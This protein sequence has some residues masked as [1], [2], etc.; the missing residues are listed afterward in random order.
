MSNTPTRGSVSGANLS[1]AQQKAFNVGLIDAM[2]T[3]GMQEGDRS[4]LTADTTLDVTQCGLVPVD[5]TGG[6]VAL[7]LPA[8]GTTTKDA[9]YLICR[10]DATANTLS[11]N[12]GGSDA[13][14][15]SASA[16][17]IAGRGI[18]GLQLP[19]GGTDWKVIGRSGGTQGGARTAIGLGVGSDIASAS[20]VDLTARTGK[21][22]RIT[23]TTTTTVVTMANG[24]E[25]LCTAAG[26]WPINISGVLTHTC[27]AGDQIL[28]SQ[29]NSGAQ[30][31]IVLNRKNPG[32]VQGSFKN[33]VVSTTGTNATVTASADE[34]SV[35]DGSGNYYTLRNVS[36][37]INSAASGAN[38]L[39]TGSIA[40]STWYSVWVGYNP[41]TNTAIGLLS[42][43]N[44]APTM[45]SGY[46]F[47]ARISR[48]RTDGTANK[49]PLG[50]KQ[51]NRKAQYLVAS[52]GNLTALPQMVTG[53][54]GNLGTPTWVSVAVDNFV[55]DTA[56]AID[57]VSHIPNAGG[58]AAGNMAAPN[59]SYGAYNSG[60][61]PPPLVNF[62]FVNSGAMA[63]RQTMTLESANIYF[64]GQGTQSLYCAGWEDNL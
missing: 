14:E 9:V 61:N 57:V 28:F 33:L 15:G 17:G 21:I 13:I 2:R 36:L 62:P 5:C 16:V 40:G 1:G 4:T 51:A 41:A 53:A 20:T 26:A 11:V 49:Y 52:G 30:K 42:L 43:S 35:G 47:K 8:S 25:V 24:D 54:Q 29:D 63:V 6:N 58:G 48:V 18:L 3:A 7:T 44:S 23:G 12:R 27:T 45:P 39:D 46:T 34:L 31:A 55:P 50:M 10:L 64:A 59:N 32:N 56:T 22:V 38:G 37:S 19:A 60:S